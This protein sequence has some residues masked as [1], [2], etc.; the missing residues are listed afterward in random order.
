MDTR[1]LSAQLQSYCQLRLHHGTHNCHL[2][3]VHWASVF[4]T[5]HAMCAVYRSVVQCVLFS[6][7]HTGTC[8]L[9]LLLAPS[10]AVCTGHCACCKG[11]SRSSS[12]S[13]SSCSYAC[14]CN[15]LC[16]V[17]TSACSV[18]QPGS[19]MMLAPLLGMCSLS[20]SLQHFLSHPFSKL[21]MCCQ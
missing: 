2:S 17:L 10:V 14:V 7:M 12:C 8:Q 21:L 1:I 16:M 6:A 20:A 11:T 3:V 4:A 13:S 18:A 15:I 9:V 19:P 5:V